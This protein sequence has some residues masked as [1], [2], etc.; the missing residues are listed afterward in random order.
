MKKKNN[1]EMELDTEKLRK[2]VS[3]VSPYLLAIR[4]PEVFEGLGFPR[5]IVRKCIRKCRRL[6][7]N[8]ER[9]SAS[10]VS[11]GVMLRIL[12]EAIGA[13]CSVG[14]AKLCI[15]NKVEAWRDAC[16]SQLDE[17]ERE[18]SVEHGDEKAG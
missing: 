12:A 3:I 11:D 13:D 15:S 14:D 18:D 1:V 6:L 16:L 2:W 4:P 7:N 10:G 8:G 17:I 5:V 9:R